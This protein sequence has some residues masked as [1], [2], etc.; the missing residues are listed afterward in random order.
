ME[1]DQ[2]EAARLRPRRIVPS[3][4]VPFGER[5]TRMVHRSLTA[6]QLQLLTG[7]CKRHGVTVH[8]ALA[9][10]MVTA[11]AR[12]AG[13]SEPAYFSIGSPVDFRRELDPAVSPGEAGS[14]AATLPSRVLYRPG[15]PLWPMAEAV[16]RDLT[17]RREREEHLSMINLLGRAGPNSSSDSEPFMRYMDEHGPINLCL[18]NLGRYDFPD[19]VGPWRVSGAQLVAGI[20]VTGALVATANTSHGQLAW[21]F[22]HV[23]GMVPAARAQHI[24]DEA[25]RTVLAAVGD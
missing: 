5:R 22:S 15:T 1:R 13:T 3:S 25:V 6:G 2:E 9:A 21:N 14:Y 12:E 4:P 24:A 19:R 7:A 23:D 20:S 10:A 16:G 8:G 17:E 11:V 18:S